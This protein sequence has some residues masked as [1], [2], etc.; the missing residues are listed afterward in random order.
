M[1]E[2]EEEPFKV[3]DRRGREKEDLETARAGASRP[4]S[5]R[6]PVE[7]RPSSGTESRQPDLQGILM[8]FAT[9]A[10][11]SLGETADPG[12]HEP[13]VDLEHAREAIDALLVLR[14]KTSGNRTEQEDRLLQE[15]VYDLQIR[16]V[17]VAEA[18]RAR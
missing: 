5:E 18:Q 12:G 2:S 17:R 7:A 15:L 1:A 10:L 6:N 8:M 9:S 4:S 11:I 16:F 13:R 3:T 14:D